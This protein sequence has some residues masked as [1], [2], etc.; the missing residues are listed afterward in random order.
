MW[1]AFLI[2]TRLRL[3]TKLYSGLFVSFDFGKKVSLAELQPAPAIRT[4]I[5]FHKRQG[6]LNMFHGLNNS[7]LYSAYKI[8]ALFADDIGNLIQG[9]GTCFFV[10]NKN[11]KLCLVT[12]RHVLDTTY[13]K[14]DSL[15]K[16]SIRA[17]TVSGRQDSSDEKETSFSII[18]IVTYHKDSNNDIACI[19]NIAILGSKQIKIDPFIPYSFL[20]QQI[21][22]QDKLSICDFLAFPGFPEWHDKLA[23]RPILRTGTISSDPR[24]DYAYG[25]TVRGACLAFEDLN[26]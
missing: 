10:E 15:K 21:D 12:N 23:S 26:S 6:S 3:S 13:K 24:F 17:I 16:F 5:Q 22:F 4:K 9:T 14:P 18:P 25:D 11:K 20:A 7:F 8:T 19:K 1:A 2:S